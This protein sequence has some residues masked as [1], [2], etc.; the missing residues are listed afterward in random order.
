M[1]K[2]NF[3]AALLWFLCVASG[4]AILFR[5]VR[6]HWPTW[7]LVLYAI[8]IYVFWETWEFRRART[9]E[10][11]RREHKDYKDTQSA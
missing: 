1:I 9:A 3:R 10:R 11:K 5:L 7:D 8:A 4:V 2:Y 6:H